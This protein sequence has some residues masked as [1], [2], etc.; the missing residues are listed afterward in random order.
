MLACTHLLAVSL[1]GAQAANGVDS[2]Q[3][4]GDIVSAFL[5]RPDVLCAVVWCAVLTAHCRCPP[6]A[7]AR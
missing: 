1:L 3:G 7:A 6:W 2:L 4:R 5:S